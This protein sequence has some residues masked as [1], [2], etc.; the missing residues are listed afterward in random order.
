MEKKLTFACWGVLLGIA[1]WQSPGWWNAATDPRIDD[2]PVIQDAPVASLGPRKPELKRRDPKL[3]YKID[4]RDYKQGDDFVRSP[5]NAEDGGEITFN[6][7]GNAG[8]FDTDGK[9]ILPLD[10]RNLH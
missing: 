4:L 5:F 7:A 6:E 8:P 1:A 2:T 9:L 3:P 10:P